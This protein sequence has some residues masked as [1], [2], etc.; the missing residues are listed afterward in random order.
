MR[1]RQMFLSE[2]A[3]FWCVLDLDTRVWF[4]TGWY[5]LGPRPFCKGTSLR[6]QSYLWFLAVVYI[7]LTR[8]HFVNPAVVQH[9]Y[10][11]NIC[12]CSCFYL[13]QKTQQTFLKSFIMIMILIIMIVLRITIGQ[14]GEGSNL[15]E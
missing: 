5:F 13:S 1:I 6:M 2:V 14:G 4:W 12:G 9:Y 7:F 15:K 3:L 10:F 11:W 8:G